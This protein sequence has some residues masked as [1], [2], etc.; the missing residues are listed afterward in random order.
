MDEGGKGM[1]RVKSLQP[2]ETV[3]DMT[4]SV[5]LLTCCSGPGPTTL[6]KDRRRRELVRRVRNFKSRFSCA[7][8][9]TWLLVCRFSE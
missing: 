5:I 9:F 8:I 3:P 7:L 6:N 1:L 2:T 4:F